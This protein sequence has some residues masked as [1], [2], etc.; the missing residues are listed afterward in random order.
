L[1]AERFRHDRSAYERPNFRY[2]CGR[3]ADWGAPC[4]RGPNPDGSCGG[5]ADCAPFLNDHNRWECRRPSAAGG[6][7]AEGPLPDGQ[8]AHRRAACRPRATLRRVRSRLTLLA[9]LLVIVGIA[10]TFKID[11]D[12]TAVFNAVNPGPLS[13]LHARFTAEQGCTACHSAHGKGAE[14][15]LAAAIEVQDMTPQ[16]VACHSFGGPERSPHNFP[17]GSPHAE[18][19]VECVACHTEHRGLAGD[20]TTMTNAQCHTCHE[21]KFAS[22]GNGHPQFGERFPYRQRTAIDFDHAAHLAK[23]FP[24]NAQKA[25]AEGCIGC[26]NVEQAAR[27]VPVLGFATMCAA[28]HEEKITQREL[29]VFALPELSPAEFLALKQDELV[30]A[31]GRPDDKI[32]KDFA[33]ALDAAR[34][35]VAQKDPQGDFQ[36]VSDQKLTSFQQSLLHS[37]GDT[38]VEREAEDADAAQLIGLLRD[39]AKDG[40]AAL[41]ETLDRRFGAGKAKLL[42]AGLSPELVRRAACSW[43][44]NAEAE[45]APPPGGGWYVK[46]LD[47]RYKPQG[48]AD[49]L[50]RAWLDFA[51]DPRGAGVE[52]GDAERFVHFRAD[53][54]DRRDGPGNCTSC[55]AVSDAEASGRQAIT[56]PPAAALLGIEWQPNPAVRPYVHYSHRP[57]LNLLGPEKGCE[58]CHVLDQQADYAASFGQLNPHDYISN[59]KQ[60]RVEQCANCHGAGRVRNDCLTCH[61]YHRTPGFRRIMTAQ[62]GQGG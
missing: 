58:Q 30:S 22:F 29:V 6:P 50:L 20:T 21:V 2:R 54:I 49:P 24:A 9:A 62:P 51:V 48:H 37:D 55:H 47:L 57:H 23:H 1:D 26:H 45:S 56:A 3:A 34:K 17:A 59:F 52:P 15:W 18:R 39:M 7:C 46:G 10:A 41:A 4:A 31:C 27:K 14:T 33:D 11:G 13:G 40:G 36:P 38:I 8:C 12:S 42:M 44:F 28:C 35:A 16:C 19:Q 60:M 43:A 61:E 32:A 5:V 25:P 53:A